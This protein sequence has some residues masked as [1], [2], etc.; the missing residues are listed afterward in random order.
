MTHTM[1]L[2]DGNAIDGVWQCLECDYRIVLQTEPKIE[3]TII[4]YGDSVQHSGFVAPD[5]LQ[6][7][8]GNVTVK[9]SQR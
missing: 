2:V 5:G 4:Q 1:A 9:E 6:L 7:Q 8:I 3:R